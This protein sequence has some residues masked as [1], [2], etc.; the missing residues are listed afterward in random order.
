M[1]QWLPKFR[2]ASPGDSFTCPQMEAPERK[3]VAM[4]LALAGYSSKM[5]R[6]VV[7]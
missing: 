7:F 6:A 5:P 3:I 2:Y 1:S 4:C